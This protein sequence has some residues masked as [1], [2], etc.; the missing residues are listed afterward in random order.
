MTKFDRSRVTV[1]DRI[2]GRRVAMR[3]D[4]VR[5]IG[6]WFPGTPGADVALD[7]LA[8]LIEGSD[9]PNTAA[10]EAYLQIRWHW[11]MGDGAEVAP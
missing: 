8:S 10:L 6:S 7:R 1:V 11:G 2:T 5:Q 9:H 4:A 3:R